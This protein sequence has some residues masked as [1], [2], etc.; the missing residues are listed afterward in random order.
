MAGRLL[1]KGQPELMELFGVQGQAGGHGVAAESAQQIRVPC[2]D[3][4]QGIANVQ[5]RYRPRRTFKLIV[6]RPCKRDNGSMY[7][8]L[9]A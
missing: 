1:V 6:G 2:G 4:V 9:Y 5:T 3:C 7:P 8:V